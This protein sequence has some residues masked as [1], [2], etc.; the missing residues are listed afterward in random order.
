VIDADGHL[1]L[2]WLGPA[3]AQAR[4]QRA[5]ALLLH[6]PAGVGQF[7]LALT[8]AQLWLC[9]D[10]AA[11]ER[12]G[13]PCGRCAGCRAMLAHRHPDLYLLLP[14]ALRAT[15]G[16]DS[17]EEGAEA[18][19]GARAK[20]K[21]S[22]EIRVDEVRQAIAWGQQTSA[23]GRGKVLLIHP[24]SAMNAVAANALLKTL[25]EPPGRLRLLLG[26]A[27]PEALLPTIRSRCQRVALS[28]PPRDVALAWLGERGVADAAVLLDAA[29][30]RPQEALALQQE[31][32]DA[33]RWRRLPQAVADGDAGPFAGAAVARVVDALLKLCHDLMLQAA[34][35]GARYFPPASLPAG[36][37]MPALAAWART[38]LRTARH[39]EHPWNAPLLFEA[40]VAEGRCCIAAAP[41]GG[42]RAATLVR[43]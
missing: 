35:A 10:G 18:D 31:G 34:G 5:H 3:L 17:A 24:A 11:P 21:P 32:F 41:P 12:D 20:A 27:D 13:R 28:L 30:G 14:A 36:A 37:A 23:R 42:A 1:P 26:C 38:L 2:P 43:R 29:G 6:G 15:L 7:E 4:R 16:C 9:E 40:L 8:L 39:D 22:R 33:A 19:G 25:E